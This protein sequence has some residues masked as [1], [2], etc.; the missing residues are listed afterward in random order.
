MRRGA[1]GV[2]RG[3][4]SCRGAVT[5][6]ASGGKGAAVSRASRPP[7]PRRRKGSR[8]CRAAAGGSGRRRAPGRRPR[9]GAATA[10]VAPPSTAGTR[11]DAGERLGAAGFSR[12][13]RPP[14]G[15]RA[16]RVRAWSSARGIF[17]PSRRTG[18]ERRR[19]GAGSRALVE[20][21]AVSA[22]RDVG[23][24][25]AIVA[26]VKPIALIVA[27]ESPTPE[28]L[29]GGGARGPGDRAC[30]TVRNPRGRVHGGRDD[31]ARGRNRRARSG[32]TAIGR[33]RNPTVPPPRRAESKPDGRRPCRHGENLRPSAI[34]EFH[35]SVRRRPVESFRR[36]SSRLCSPAGSWSTPPGRR[37]GR[38]RPAAGRPAGRPRPFRCR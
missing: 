21:V 18:D 33:V 1:A 23:D 11:D 12:P 13:C 9:G 4:R 35:A 24:L 32:P 38:P 36:Q 5:P 34:R 16:I 28:E 8:T 3:R 31:T 30:P 14:P 2:R 19:R 29:R 6:V 20:L 17:P 26:R 22:R 27:L 15:R 7:N 37:A 10:R 25:L